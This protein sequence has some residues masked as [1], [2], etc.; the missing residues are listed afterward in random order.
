MAVALARTDSI[1]YSAAAGVGMPVVYLG[2]KTGRDGIHGATMASAEFD[3]KTEE[4]APHRSG[5]RSLFREASARSLPRIDGLGRGHRD[6]GYGRGGLTCSAVEM[7][8]KGDL[9][10]EA[11]SRR[12]AL[13]RAGMSAY[14]MMLSESQER[15]LMVLKPEMESI[16]RAI[17]EKW[18]LD[19]RGGRPHDRHAALRGQ[20]QGEV[21]ADLPIKELG[22]QAPE[23]DRPHTEPKTPA[24]LDPASVPAPP[25]LGAALIRLM[26]SPDLASRRWIWSSMTISFWATQCQRPGGTRAWWRLDG[27]LG[28]TLKG[29]ALTTDVTPR[30]VAAD[31][32]E[33]R[34]AG[35]SPRLIRI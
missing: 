9:G 20:H 30:Y 10:L 27:I 19:F 28:S 13:P 11:R 23:Y 6:P 16:A 12:R 22:D 4:K 33:G 14:E 2:S 7:G 29:L 32:F 18:D 26:G 35:P 25:D 15:M 17:F 31:P 5:R 21:M 8:A 3:D 24:S 1:F 34:Q